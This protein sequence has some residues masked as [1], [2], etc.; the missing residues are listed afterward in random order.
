MINNAHQAMKAKGGS[1][2][3]TVKSEFDDAMIRIH[4]ID[5]GPGILKE[6]LQKIFEPLFTT[7]ADGEGTGLGLSICYEIIREHDGT[8]YVAS[9]PGT[10]ACFVIEIPISSKPS[11]MAP[12]SSEKDREMAA[13]TF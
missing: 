3:L 11:L 5:T 7:K 4:F 10:G 13:Q 2:T 12:C 8:I 6:N 9:E 1:G